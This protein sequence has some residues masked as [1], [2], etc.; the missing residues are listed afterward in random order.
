M[1]DTSS[2]GELEFQNTAM[3]HIVD[4]AKITVTRREHLSIKG[5]ASRSGLPMFGEEFSK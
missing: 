4:Y 2:Q 1:A 3:V 5:Q